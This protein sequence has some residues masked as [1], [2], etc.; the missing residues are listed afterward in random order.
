MSP[1]GRYVAALGTDAGRTRR[2]PASRNLPQWCFSNL[3]A[4]GSEWSELVVELGVCVGG[5]SVNWDGGLHLS[6]AWFPELRFF[7]FQSVN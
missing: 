7:A 1:Q 5:G 4:L 2:P 3:P 6:S